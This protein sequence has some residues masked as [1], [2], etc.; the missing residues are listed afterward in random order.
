MCGEMVTG[1]PLQALNSAR[2]TGS[3]SNKST[4]E[5]DAE[6]IMRRGV[7][8]VPKCKNMISKYCCQLVLDNK[9]SSANMRNG[10][11][12]SRFVPREMSRPL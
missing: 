12:I 6:V 11:N 3:P 4:A 1:I 8:D 5:L 2:V 9:S 10:I 7:S